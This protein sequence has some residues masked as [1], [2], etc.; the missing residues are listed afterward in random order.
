MHP[1]LAVWTLAPDHLVVE[2]PPVDPTGLALEL[3]VWTVDGRTVAYWLTERGVWL[4]AVPA[5]GC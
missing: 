3:H 4:G 2:L 1:T 5:A